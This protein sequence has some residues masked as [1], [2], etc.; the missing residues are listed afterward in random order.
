[1]GH[2]RVAGPA[3]QQVFPETIDLAMKLVDAL[4]IARV[5]DG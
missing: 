3:M 2:G 1:L 5:G 4:A